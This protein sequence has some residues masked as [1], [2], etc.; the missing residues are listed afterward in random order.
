MER[1]VFAKGVCFKKIFIFFIIGCIAG[2]YYEELLFIFKRGYW[3][4]RRGLIYGPFSPV[5]GISLAVFLI[6][7]GKKIEKMSALKVYIYSCLLGGFM[8]YILNIS[9]ELIFNSRSW[10]YNGYFL[11]IGGRTTIPFMLFWGL[12]GLT[13]IKGIYPIISHLIEKIPYKIGNILFTIIFIFVIF[14]IVL[15][16]TA[17]LR[18]VER[19]KGNPPL[20]FVGELCD[21]FYPDEVIKSIYPNAT[22]IK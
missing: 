2:T 14:D 8:E 5:Y 18:Q 12:L 7:F 4:P 20:S 3:S 21:E 1:K 11:N 17:T 22:T 9:Q 6:F 15:S 10:N 19:R 13:F 16:I